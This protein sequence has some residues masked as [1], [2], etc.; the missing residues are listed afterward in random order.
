MVIKTHAATG[1]R[2]AAGN[3]ISA[4]WDRSPMR[5]PM[6]SPS[7]AQPPVTTAAD[8]T[9]G[10]DETDNKGEEVKRAHSTPQGQSIVEAPP[11]VQGSN[12]TTAPQQS[13]TVKR[14]FGGSLL[15][16]LSDQ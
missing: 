9:P 4:V 12:A 3:V 10:R 5:S 11:R 13:G 1:Q 16:K 14:K 6:R 15:K 7:P 8:S 2:S